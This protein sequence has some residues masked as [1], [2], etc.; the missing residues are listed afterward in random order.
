MRN[1]TAAFFHTGGGGSSCQRHQNRL[2]QTGV[3]APIPNRYDRTILNAN[4]DKLG[5]WLEFRLGSS[6]IWAHPHREEKRKRQVLSQGSEQCSGGGNFA[7]PL[8]VEKKIVNEIRC[9]PKKKRRNT[10]ITVVYTDSPICKSATHTIWA[11]SVQT[12]RHSPPAPNRF[13]EPLLLEHS[14]QEGWL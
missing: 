8:F 11:I 13:G 5:F 7:N 4:R 6:F 9:G 1:V 12:Q 14:L 2:C 10:K 3:P